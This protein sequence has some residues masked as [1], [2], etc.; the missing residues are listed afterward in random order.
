MK[1]VYLLT[2]TLVSA[3]IVTVKAQNISIN[4]TGLPNSTSSMLEVLQP[5]GAASGTKGLHVTHAGAAG[6]TAYAIWAEATG[7]A[8]KYA[9]VV[10]STGG[11]VG[12]G[13]IT[14][15]QKLDVA[16]NINM[17]TAGSTIYASGSQSTYG[18]LTIQG[19]KNGWGGINFRDG[20]GSNMKTLMIYPSYSGIFNTADNNWDWYWNNG[21]LE[22][23]NGYTPTNQIMRM[24]PNLHFNSVTGNA[25]IVNWDNGAVGAGTQ[26]FRV[27]NGAGVD[28]FYVT[29]SGDAVT[30]RYHYAQ[31]FNSSDNAVGAGI[32]GVMI[33]A[34]DNYLRTGTAAAVNTFLGIGGAG[35][36]GFTQ[37]NA[38]A[39][40]RYVG[41][42]T[43]TY[44]GTGGVCASGYTTG[45][46]FNVGGL[47][48]TRT[49]TSGNLVAVN[50]HIRWKTDNYS[51]WAPETVWYRIL[52]DGVEIA[53]SSM[54]T[55]DI[56]WYILEGDGNI[57]FY[58]SGA[59]AGSH[60]YSI[61]TAMANNAA[62]T[63]SYWV[64]D[65][66]ITLMEIKQ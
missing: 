2:L 49:I 23:M 3:G 63:E 43:S 60:T 54:F 59:S 51:Y 7:A 17:S 15:T 16:G 44:S 38:T 32:T 28:Q 34:G 5:A 12:I 4:T 62:G 33:K 50:T 21:A 1:K 11:N 42:N 29:S 46:W 48:I 25:V 64:Q 45:T 13:T 31:Y 41:D 10:P 35:G 40:T 36:Q 61:Q 58:D 9:I 37:S 47:S 20:A 18:A 22:G 30:A 53:R 8:N 14:P 56:D 19:T 57:F 24:T 66:Y 26:E 55:A 6:G 65:G 27:G 39:C 52:R